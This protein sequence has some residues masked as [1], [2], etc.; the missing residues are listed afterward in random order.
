MKRFL[1]LFL[2]IAFPLLSQEHEL[3]ICCIFRDDA[4]YLPE[5]VEFHQKQGVQH[6]YMYNNLSADE[7]EKFLRD[8]VSE[9]LV[10]IIDWPYESTGQ[11]FFT[12]QCNAY[13][14]CVKKHNNCKWIA[15]LDSDE[16]L[17][18]P[19]KENLR[20]FLKRYVQYGAVSAFW[21]MYGTSGINVPEGCNI[22]DYLLYR[23]K[24]DHP[25]HRTMKTIAQTKY[26][27]GIINP[28]FVYLSPGKQHIQFEVDRLRINH[29]WSRDI[30]FFYNKKLPRRA[31]W[32]N[33]NEGQI[34]LERELNEVFDPIL[35]NPDR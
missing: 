8:Y 21:M 5:W 33:N 4:K 28:H 29:Y 3:A 24:D 20:S 14:D 31:K 10:T 1:V 26:I 34:N 16:F 23:A 22:T 27:T 9:G 2:Y 17:F 6:F 13:M 30:D 18:C 25:T 15:F 32:Y 11:D 35:S 7:P 12:I 19:S